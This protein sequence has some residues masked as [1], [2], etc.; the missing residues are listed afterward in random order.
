MDPPMEIGPHGIM[1]VLMDATGAAVGLWQPKVHHG[2]GAIGPHGFPCWF[3]VNSPDM[4]AAAAF[5]QAL[6][7][8]TAEKMP[9]MEYMTLSDDRPRHGVLQMTQEWEGV[10]PHWMVYFSHHN[11]DEA[12]AYIGDNGGKVH[13]GPFD[14]PAGRIAVSQ[15][16]QG[17]MFTVMTP[18]Q[19]G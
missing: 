13:Y 1:T 6:F 16:P 9:G 14:T 2:F 5:Y 18:A 15:D 19:P 10:P 8:L 12:A 4:A 17:A 7:G 3:E 11:V